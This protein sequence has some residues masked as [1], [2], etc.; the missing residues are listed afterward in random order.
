MRARIDYADGNFDR[1]AIPLELDFHPVS[2][3]WRLYDRVARRERYG[4]GALTSAARSIRQLAEYAPGDHHEFTPYVYQGD[5]QPIH[6]L[7]PA[8]GEPDSEE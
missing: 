2:D 1:A 4:D 7:P 5:P 6:H 3:G 8:D